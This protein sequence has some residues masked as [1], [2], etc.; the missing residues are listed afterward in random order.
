MK[1]K[2]LAKIIAMG[3]AAV[4]A[5]SLLAGC[6]N[7][8]A[9]DAASGKSKDKLAQ[10][11]ERG[12][13]VVGMNA[14]FAPYE[15]HASVDGKDVVAGFDVS[16][17]KEIAKDLGVDLEIK[18]MEFESLLGALSAD[19]CDILISGLAITDKRKQQAD[20]SKGYYKGKNVLLVNKENM[21]GTD[22][23]EALTGKNI[24]I[25][26]S[27]TQ[28]EF[29]KKYLEPQ[30]TQITYIGSMNTL[31]LSL[32][33]KQIDGI[34][35]D[36]LVSRTIAL[37]NPQLTVNQKC[38]LP[39]DSEAT[40]ENPDADSVGVAMPKGQDGLREEINKTIDRLQQ[41]GD[42]ERFIDEACQ[43]SA[44]NMDQ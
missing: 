37:S 11:K 36:D 29:A 43:L 3:L 42:M 30:G 44:Q 6:T 15:F 38:V 32:T 25:Q 24:G 16:L 39:E 27:S 8:D 2:M 14:E 35:T 5:L 23:V 33:A 10:I 17:A 31:L 12:K 4:S 7:A 40:A 22:T 28:Q 18:E 13:I 19:Q 20:F 1:N 26:M 9:A 21:S 34:V 41:S